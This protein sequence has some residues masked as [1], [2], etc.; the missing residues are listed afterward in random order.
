MMAYLWPVAR[1]E[2]G[3]PLWN[4]NQDRPDER[5]RDAN[6]A[7]AVCAPLLVAET[8]CKERENRSGEQRAQSGQHLQR[9]I[10]LLTSQLHKQSERPVPKDARALAWYH[11]Y[12]RPQSGRLRAL[13][14]ARPRGLTCF[15]RTLQ[16]DLP[17]VSFPG[18][19]A[20]FELPSLMGTRTY[21][22]SSQGF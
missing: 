18:S 17:R 1:T 3:A 2:Q 21:S 9:Q 16:S 15:I 11:L 7:H 10:H 19:L 8:V 14:R 6:Q 22:S 13:Y 5:K 20:A 4:K 12:S